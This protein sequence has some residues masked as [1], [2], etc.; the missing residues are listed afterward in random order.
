MSSLEELVCGQLLSTVSM[1]LPLRLSRHDL[2][3]G[4]FETLK[5]RGAQ[6]ADRS[7]SRFDVMFKFQGKHDVEHMS[8]SNP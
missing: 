7:K 6:R 3:E 1:A 5:E 4:R 2:D 8:R